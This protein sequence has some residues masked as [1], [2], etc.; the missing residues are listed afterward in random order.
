[1]SNESPCC[2]TLEGRAPSPF[3]IF[4]I[5]WHDGL[6]SG[7]A[8]CRTCDRAYHFDMMAWDAEHEQRVYGFKEVSR[9]SYEAFVSMYTQ[10]TPSASAMDRSDVLTLCVRDALATNPERL[11]YIGAVDLATEVLGTRRLNFSDWSIL[12]AFEPAEPSSR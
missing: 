11:L 2:Q 3:E 1:M 12:L 9:R 4:M 5:G 7:V 6:T 8:R 10:A